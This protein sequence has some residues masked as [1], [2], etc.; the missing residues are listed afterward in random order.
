MFKKYNSQ[1]F[2]TYLQCYT[3]L[4]SSLKLL[5]TIRIQV[6]FFWCWSSIKLE[7][8]I[9][10]FNLVILSLANNDVG[11]GNQYSPK[12]SPWNNRYYR[13]NQTFQASSVNWTQI[14]PK[15]SNYV[16]N[17]LKINLLSFEILDI[18]WKNGILCF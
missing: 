5:Q 17:F 16:G 10:K 3:F 1:T 7:I 14:L 11:S 13:A 6:I 12:F 2:L 18:K 8:S 9:W 15:L 4:G